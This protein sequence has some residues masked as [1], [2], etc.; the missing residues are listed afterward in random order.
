MEL[1]QGELKWR[2]I[3]RTSRAGASELEQVLPKDTESP[4]CDNWRFS[5]EKGFETRLAGNSHSLVYFGLTRLPR[6][7][8]L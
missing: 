2:R 7:P 1:G 6:L 3:N 8:R 5:V 4:K